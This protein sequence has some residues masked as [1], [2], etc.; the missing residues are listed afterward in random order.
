MYSAQDEL[1][2]LYLL[3]LVFIPIVLLLVIIAKKMQR[4]L[5]LIGLE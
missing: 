4:F 3:S 5:K 2:D 1:F